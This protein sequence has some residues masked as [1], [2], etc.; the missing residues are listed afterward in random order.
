MSS[1]LVCPN[2]LLAKYLAYAVDTVAGGAQPLEQLVWIAKE[3]A[4]AMQAGTAALAALKVSPVFDPWTR[5]RK[6]AR[7]GS[8][9]AVASLCSPSIPGS[10]SRP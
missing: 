9:G 2:T 6:A 7:L 1:V 5:P 4:V 8:E 10:S 3:T